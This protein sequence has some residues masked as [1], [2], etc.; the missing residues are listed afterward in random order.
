M[1]HDE[2]VVV[3]EEAPHLEESEEVHFWQEDL[4]PFVVKPDP[5]SW[6]LAASDPQEGTELEGTGQRELS[7]FSSLHQQFPDSVRRSDCHVGLIAKDAYTQAAQWHHP[8][9][10]M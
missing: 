3:K 6:E 7:K 4:P 9:V 2:F 5:D 8:V 1:N 10:G